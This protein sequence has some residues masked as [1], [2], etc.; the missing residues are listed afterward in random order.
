MSNFFNVKLMLNFSKLFFCKSASLATHFLNLER[1]QASDK[2]WSGSIFQPLSYIAQLLDKANAPFLKF[3][4]LFWKLNIKHFLILNL[5]RS[6]SPVCS[7]HCHT[8]SITNDKNCHK[9]V[10]LGR[11]CA[12][13]L[14]KS[15][16]ILNSPQTY[17][18]KEKIISFF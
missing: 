5:S 18:C 11:D 9:A 2:K 1:A 6:F 15:S 17:F 16:L 7:L 14:G 3:W 8:V 10:S 4:N 12:E 13:A